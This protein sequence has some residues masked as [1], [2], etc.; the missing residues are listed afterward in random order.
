MIVY[1]DG[2]SQF[3]SIPDNGYKSIYVPTFKNDSSYLL[4]FSGATVQGSLDASTEMYYTISVG[5][6]EKKAPAI[7]S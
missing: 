4:A 2:K 7:F 3:I 1:P 6:E 5:K